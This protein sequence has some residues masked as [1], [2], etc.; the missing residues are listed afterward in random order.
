MTSYRI[1]TPTFTTEIDVDTNTIINSGPMLAWTLGKDF[2]T[3]REYCNKTG[4][5][6]E[7]MLG[8]NGSHVSW[9][10]YK[11]EGYELFWHEDVLQRVTWHPKNGDARDLSVSE[12][13]EVLRKLL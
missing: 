12:M 3:F 10:E 1:H 2:D 7:P 5:T 9:L 4:W 6:I 8:N 11:S 13:P